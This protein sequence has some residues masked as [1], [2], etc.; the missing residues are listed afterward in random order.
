[1]GKAIAALTRRNGGKLFCIR[2]SLQRPPPTQGI[3][4]WE[5]GLAERRVVHKAIA[6]R[7]FER[8]QQTR[9]RHERR[10]DG[11]YLVR[12]ATICCAYRRAVESLRVLKKLR[13]T[14]TQLA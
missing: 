9:Q 4:R 14:A 7:V 2:A 10:V 12:I 11:V 1:M 5:L 8:G 6:V 3:E 13:R